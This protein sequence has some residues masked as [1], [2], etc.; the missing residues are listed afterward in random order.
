[1]LFSTSTA[2]F[3][4]FIFSFLT[5]VFAAPTAG[6][7]TVSVNGI[8]IP[9][10]NPDAANII[11]NRYIV[12]YQKNASDDDVALHQAA[13]ATHLRKRELS[14]VEARSLDG[15]TLQSTVDCFKLSTWRGMALDAD[16]ATILSIYNDKTVNYI[17]ADTT[18]QVNSLVQQV[19]APA[20][21]IRISHATKGQRSYI[22]DTSAGA[23]VVAYVVDTGIRTTHSEFGGR[24]IW[25]NN[26]VNTNNTD[27]NGHGSHVAGT[28]GGA[29]YGVS[30]AVELVAVKV[31]DAQGS[32]TTSK[33]LAGLDWVETNV[34]ARG[35][36]GKS[37]V[38]ISIGGAFSSALNSAIAGLTGA[39]VTV[40]VAAGNDAVDASGV[41]PASASTALT[42]GAF[43]ATTDVYASFS[44]FGKS[45][46]VF[47][48][49]VSV[50]SVGFANDTASA[51]LS[52]TSMA[53][54][55]VAGLAAYLIGLENLTTPAAVNARVVQLAGA[56]GKGITGAPSGTTTLIAYN[57][58]GY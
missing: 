31:L 38:N 15:R 21:L 19:T 6:S 4:I 11:A 52:G 1:M 49:G 57:G 2:T 37:V 9:I 53:S 51:T 54:P 55:H 58:D 47:A 25:G 20:G 24:A 33:L 36:S 56:T 46:D 39:G 28:I 10:S 43:D 5:L 14:G 41:S 42:V 44:N 18:I 7:T 17:E 22:F 12:V 16:D 8:G 13:V 27:E 40:A 23:G 35:L 34:T 50:L 26:F 45:V 29:T 48:P 3:V 30:K 32:G